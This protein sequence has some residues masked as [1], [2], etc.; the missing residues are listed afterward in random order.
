[1]LKKLKKKFVFATMISLT[2]VIG[3]I[4]GAIN[5]FNYASVLSAADDM[6]TFINQ[7]EGKLPTKP[8]ISIPGLDI[9]F[10]PETP[11]ESRYFTVKT[12]DGSIVSVDT[13][14]IAAINHDNAIKM[15]KFSLTIGA[16]KGFIENYRYHIN[17]EGNE[18]T[19]IYLDCTRWLTT[20]NTFLVASI[21]VSAMSL[22]LLFILLNIISDRIVKPVTEGYER[23]KEFITNAG[24]DI[25]TPLTIIDADAELVE[26]ELGENEWISDIK[27]QTQ[28]LTTLTNELIYL[29]RMDELENLPH[30]DFPLSD[31]VEEVICS[32]GALVKTRN[33]RIDTKITPA[34]YLHGD[35]G[36]IRKMLTILLDNAIK[37]SP[38]GEIVEF[39]LKKQN[40]SIVI[41]LSNKAPNLSDDD[42]KHMFDR[43]YRSDKSRSSSGG[44]GIGLSV[45]RAIVSSHKG[46]ISAE[47]HGDILEIGITLQ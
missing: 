13:T 15:A 35:E 36:A 47:K 18:T 22:F 28:R 27:K 29:A 12:I 17:V 44:F 41:K 23:Q 20:V 6:I 24:H 1:M 5:L 34:L 25:K 4:V 7:N 10:T 16:K 37:Y 3:I 19:I 39:R 30:N 26:M 46:K 32:F 42:I 21:S 40:R 33:I 14:S 2:V 31:T 38:E 43:F 11:Y 8:G 9:N 45:A